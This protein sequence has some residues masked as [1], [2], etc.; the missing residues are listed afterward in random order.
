MT[1]QNQNSDSTI[2]TRNELIGLTGVHKSFGAIHV[3]KGVSLSIMEGEVVVIIGPSGGGKSTL[4]RTMNFLGM[5]DD[6]EMRIDGHPILKAVDGK[7]SL[8][9]SRRDLE[10]LR[11]DV[12][13]VFKYGNLFPHRKVIDNVMEGPLYVRHRPKNEVREEAAALLTRFGLGHHL[14]HY[15]SQL[16]GGEQQRASICRALAMKPRI[17]LFD[18]PTASLDP[19]LVGEV[20]IVLDE[21][22]RDGMTM[23]V[24]THE[25]GFARQVASRV[26][27]I[28]D[29]NIV[30][31]GPP[32]KLFGH[33]EHE[34]TQRFLGRVLNPLEEARAES[35]ADGSVA[36]T[37]TSITN[38][39]QSNGS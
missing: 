14:E 12:G 2:A 36:L 29:G 10:V 38:K 11:Q 33:P 6:G 1:K 27:F 20:L 19:E 17:M 5:P 35:K 18:E 9:P 13:M 3:L 30:E 28:D 22:A 4:I 37:E 16:S 32:S 26:C 23:V 21:L 31:Q 25:M 24:V 8:K 15:P 34:R 39:P 7:F